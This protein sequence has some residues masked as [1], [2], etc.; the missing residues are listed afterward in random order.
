M[1]GLWLEVRLPRLKQS[2]LSGS[3]VG[4]ET[5]LLKQASQRQA[6][7]AECASRRNRRRELKSKV[8]LIDMSSCLEVRVLFGSGVV[9]RILSLLRRSIGLHRCG[10]VVALNR[11]KRIH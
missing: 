5:F 3:R 6:T 7:T 4:D 2:R 1:T 10:N 9:I 8:G 11:H